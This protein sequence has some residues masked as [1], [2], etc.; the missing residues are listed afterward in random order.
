MLSPLPDDAARQKRLAL[1]ATLGMLMCIVIFG[2]NFAISRH[3]LLHGLTSHDMLALRFLTAGLLL[4]PVF[5]KGGVLAG[6]GTC[7][8]IGWGRGLLLTVMSGFPMSYMVMTGLSYSPAAHGATIGPGTVT[9]IGIVGSVILFGNK[10]TPRLLLGILSVLIGL[11]TLA[12]A[13]TVHAASGVLRGDLCFLAVG[14]LWGGYPL[15]MQYWKLDAL[16]ATAVVSV[17]SMA[18]L[19]IYGLFFFRGFDVAPWWVL[20]L[21]AINQG[22][23]NIIVGLWIWGWAARVLGAAV[24]GRFPPLIPV[25]GTLLAIP[26]LA[27]IPGP[28]QI[29]G[30]ALIVGGLC[31]AS[32]RSR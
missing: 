6:L 28:A 2:A 3:A 15:A 5:L 22:V 26:I 30:I 9:V 21:H 25:A 1:F 13:G 12:Y 18:Y 19:P 20:V 16:K 14:L 27:E 10:V 29:I 24:V 17:L 31:L 23:L 4:L 32:W 8:G 7:A 11:G